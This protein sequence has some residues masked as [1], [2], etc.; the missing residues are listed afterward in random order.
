M[1][2]SRSNR[3]LC[4]G[5]C[6]IMKPQ[7]VLGGEFTKT[8]YSD[9]CSFMLLWCT[10]VLFHQFDFSCTISINRCIRTHNI[11]LSK[12]LWKFS[13]TSFKTSRKESV[14]DKVSSLLPVAAL[15]TRSSGNIYVQNEPTP[16]FL[17][18]ILT[19]FIIDFD[20]NIRNQV[21]AK[22]IRCKL[23]ILTCLKIRFCLLHFFQGCKYQTLLW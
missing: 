10:T 11:S 16:L 5:F 17:L 19:I 6:G 13:D 14:F 15:N 2:L 21:K 7:H 20:W 3:K 1:F 4:Y 23:K 22:T 12:V 9:K 18:M 8:S